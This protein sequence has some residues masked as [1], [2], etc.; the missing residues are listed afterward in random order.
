[1]LDEPWSDAALVLALLGLAALLSALRR[2]L[3]QGSR[4]LATR[5]PERNGH[6]ARPHAPPPIR[7]RVLGALLVG[8]LALTV[9]AVALGTVALLDLHGRDGL[10]YAI[11]GLSLAV[12]AFEALARLAVRHD[13]VDLALRPFGLRIERYA[14]KLSATDEIRGRLD[15]LHQS[16]DVVKEERDMMGGLLDLKELSVSEVMVHRRRCTPS[17]PPFRRP[18]SCAR[19]WALPTR[20]CRS[21]AR[22]PRTSSASCT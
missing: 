3:A 16:G 22:R 15:L 7:A 6:D 17:T 14:E 8:N 5:G 20:A 18:R 13:L 21:G 10:A 4:P 1:M 2:R 12:V 9:A 11:G 19:C